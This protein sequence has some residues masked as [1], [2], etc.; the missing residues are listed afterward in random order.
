MFGV[1]R[2]AFPILMLTAIIVAAGSSQR[3]GFD[4]LFA[5]L[6]GKPVVAHAIDAFEQTSSVDEIVL[7][8]RNERLGELQDIVR[9][10]MFRKVRK[11]IAGGERRQDSVRAGLA[12]TRAEFVAVHDAARPLV[13]PKQIEQV[14]E[15]ARQYGA[16]ALA[17]PVK[18][19]LKRVDEQNFIC[20]SVER[21][22]TYALQ[23]PQIVSR[24]VLSKA[25]EAIFA[26]NISVTDET[27]AVEQVGGK[28]AIVTNDDFNFKIT[29]ANDLLLAE[30]VLKQRR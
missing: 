16:A 21:E 17:E 15:A 2:S 14:F 1:R 25:Y 13:R 19:T 26:K 5:L 3:M 18:D 8:G 22:K 20:G 4:K 12:E 11:V 9:S 10:Q 29:F 23:T 6:A 30:A 24:E 7:V 27:S 28:V